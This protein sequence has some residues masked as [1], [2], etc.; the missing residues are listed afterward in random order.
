MV[1]N[2]LADEPMNKGRDSARGTLTGGGEMG[3]LV[4]EYDW[5]ST[6]LGPV[7]NWSASLKMMVG[8]L[9]AN[10][11]PLLLW[12]GPDYIS[13]YNDAYRP[14]L[15]TKHPWAIGKPVR[16]CWSE[17]HHILKPLIDTPFKGGPSTWMEDILLE[18]NRYG[19]LEETHFTIAYSPVPD[20]TTPTGIGGVLAT[21]VEI[22]EK[23][24]GERRIIALRDLGARAAQAKTAEQACENAAEALAAH[25]KDIPFALLYLL[26]PSG[27][28]ARLAGTTGVEM[29]APAAPLSIDIDHADAQFGWPL[30]DVLVSK[31]SQTVEKLADRFTQ[32]PSGPW[33]DPPHTAVI[34]PI[35][36][37]IPHELAGF[38][39]TGVSSR[40]KLDGQYL[41]FFDLA[42]T[43]I[44]TA[45]ASARAY[46][47][48][49]KR[50]EALAEIDRTKT[51]FFSNVSHE[52]R[53]P[54][55]LMLGPLEDMKRMA[56]GTDGLSTAQREQLDLIH[57][58]GLR[59]LKLVNTLLDF[60]R[61][62]AGRVQAIYVPTDLA[63]Y[64]EDLASVFR[65]AIEKAGLRLIVD[66]P[67]LSERAYV[68]RDMWE[69]IVLNLLSNAFKFTSEGEIEVS[70]RPVGPYFELAVRDT[71]T[72]IPAA[73][74]PRVFERFHRVD[75]ARGR[76]HE[77]TG[78]GL[79]L[80]QELARLHGGS[81]SVESEQGKGSTFRVRIPQ[82]RDHLPASQIGGARSLSSTALGA[83]PF[84]EEAMR[85][86]PDSR[87]PA[88]ESELLMPESPAP[89][90]TKRARIL[91]ADDNADMRDYLRRLLDPDYD[92]RTV[93][94]GEAALA[95]IKQ[96][97]PDLL[98]ADVMMPRMD[99]FNVLTRLRADS[100][101]NTLPVILL[102]ARAGEEA[103]VEG[104][105]AGAND[106]LVKPFS[107][108]ELLA[109]VDMNIR[110][111]K[112]RREAEQTLRES[113]ERFRH[114]ADNAPV[115]VWISEPD[116]RSTFLSKS[117]YDFTGQRPET[118]M[119]FGWLDAVHPD[120]RRATE[121]A[122]L[123]ANPRREGFRLEYRLRRN[124]GEYCWAID[125]ASPRLGPA[126]ELLGYIGSV[127]DI[128]DRKRLEQAREVMIAE[129]HHRTRNLLAVVRSISEQTLA[130]SGSLKDFSALFNDRLSALSRV[131]GLLA[132]DGHASIAIGEL[133]RQELKALGAEVTGNRVH[134]EGESVTLPKD[135]VQI[136]LLV[137]HELA[138]NALKHGALRSREGVLN[139]RWRTVRN[140][141]GP[142]L[143][144]EWRESGVVL[145][146]ET[147]GRARTGYGRQLIEQ[148]LPYQLDAEASFMMHDDGIRCT[149]DMPL[150]EKR[151]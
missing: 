79:A 61:I 110:M 42:A 117:W 44:S 52:F 150:S 106:Y 50:A 137:L 65:A 149:I 70:L 35:K 132:S 97:A 8:F 67:P 14:I 131:Q 85:W 32:L 19:F 87:A 105:A 122:Y 9:L 78:I 68:D 112:L 142:R 140:G 151:A 148:A 143:L 100:A 11:F 64:T 58:N 126:G 56:D 133:V 48:E 16:E 124:D 60:S 31:N 2:A 15:G 53:T 12:W 84:V 113:E 10:R 108:R 41:S 39:V 82:G 116:G 83:Q 146:P 5:A 18:I 74:L 6:P 47:E 66:S 59:L 120:D 92:V 144:L 54:L 62:E 127:I 95:A 73:E 55:T 43:Q 102:S 23:V 69:K 129:L 130:K 91:V 134:L 88:P 76:T 37:N 109:R 139:V 24:V 72:G 136:L 115:M 71:G 147:I 93:A 125:A 38:M 63:A 3:S 27:R 86:L 90:D 36:S 51:A 20:D 26:D 118:G 135:A 111:E 34:L 25:A 138:T 104:L 4:R 45:I 145:D 77:G 128:S 30:G 28:T 107:A 114:M 33:S 57:R 141:K 17:I 101:T 46:E 49:R 29:G 103:K 40:L 13:I 75:G 94:D 21:V 99:G 81:V 1:D 7:E 89:S 123:A 119:G 96:D 121:Q 22:T 80:V 98:L